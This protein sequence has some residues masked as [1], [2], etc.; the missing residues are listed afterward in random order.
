MLADNR[1][2]RE[3]QRAQELPLLRSETRNGPPDQLLANPVLQLFSGLP[4]GPSLAFFRLQALEG[5]GS[6]HPHLCDHQPEG[7]PD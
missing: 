5:D 1:V 2:G 3:S 4:A 6:D 7:V